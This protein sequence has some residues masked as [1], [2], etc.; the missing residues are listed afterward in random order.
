MIRAKSLKNVLS[1]VLIF[2]FT[3]ISFSDFAFK[4]NVQEEEN[5]KVNLKKISLQS[6]NA[7][8]IKLDSSLSFIKNVANMVSYFDTI[9][10]SEIIPLL[11]SI[12]KESDFQRI[13][14]VSPDGTSHTSDGKIIDVSNYQ[15]FKKAISGE[16]NISEV[17]KSQ[18]DKKDTFAVATPIFNKNNKVIGILYGSY[19]K[20]K[21]AEFI[22]I[23]SFNS[24]GYIDIFESSGK[25]VL[26]SSHTNKLIKSSSNNIYDILKK[27][28]F[29]DGYSYKKIYE[30]IKNNKSGFVSYEYKG[31]NGYATY[32]PID[33]NDWYVLSVI[34]QHTVRKNIDKIN[35]LAFSLIFKVFLLFIIL[36]IYIF[37]KNNKSQRHILKANKEISSITNS[38][39][40]GVQKCT[41]GETC[42]FNFLSDGFIDLFGYTREEIKTLFNNNFYSLIHKDDVKR[43]KREI[44]EQVCKNKTIELEYRVITKSGDTVWVLD[45]GEL[46]TEPDG[47]EYF[48][49]VTVDITRT[50]KLEKEMKQKNLELEMVSENILGGILITEFNEDFTIKYTNSGYLS[51]IGYTR[52]QL[53]DELQSKACNLIFYDDRK[54]ALEN[55]QHQLNTK[56][57]AVYEHRI[58]RRDGN[59][60]WVSIKGR[61][62]IDD[63]GIK[64]GIWII[65]DITD[66]KNAEQKLKINEERF[67]I[68]LKQTSNT[69]FEYDIKTKSLLNTSKEL[70]KYNIYKIVENVPYSLVES[71]VIHK[72]FSD[73]FINMYENVINGAKTASCVVKIKLPDGSYIWN[74][75]TLTT[76]FDEDGNPVRAIGI[77]EDISKQKE[78]EIRYNEEGKYHSAILSEAMITYEINVS[79]DT[80]IKGNESWHKPFGI[81]PD[82][83]YSEM[84][85]TIA[86]S[87]IHKDNKEVFL[88]T[89]LCKNLLAAYKNNVTEIKLEYRRM[90][91]ENKMIWVVCTMHLIKDSITNDIKA[92]AYVKD[93]DNQKK[94]EIRLKLKAERDTLTGLYNKGTTEKLINDFLDSEEA[95]SGIHAFLIVDIDNFKSV[96]DN[97]GHVFGD[98]VLFEVSKHLK[99]I[100]RKDD[101][102]GRIGGDEFIAFLKN[103]QSFENAK[104]KAEKICDIFRN[105]YTENKKT[106]KISGTVGISFVPE[107][108]TIFKELYRKADVALY[109]AKSKGKDKYALYDDYIYQ[110]ELKN[111]ISDN[112]IKELNEYEKSKPILKEVIDS[113]DNYMYIVNPNTYEL[114][115][116]NNK[117]E[118]L[119][120]GIKSGETCYKALLKSNSPCNNCPIKGLKENRHSK[121]KTETNTFG[122]N[123]SIA[124][125]INWMEGEYNC[126][127]E[128]IDISLYKK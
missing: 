28:S 103:I 80:F 77:Q 83:N 118:N 79:K 121:F 94:E 71:G 109:Y 114:I 95:S 37:Y 22:D 23:T 124:S 52:E 17:V 40:G 78:A 70:D 36:I 8:K 127:I 108:G 64:K 10:N 72:D 12:S 58:R 21:L 46:I 41:L 110:N 115:I 85:K 104:K 92:L 90:N 1:I 113:I 117:I 74:K 50:K 87:I 116:V 27:A 68:A 29:D 119:D 62:I 105:S 39:P 20:D 42:E 4:T 47:K 33:I 111:N 51:M 65:T 15:Y 45:K 76:I 59:I 30:D 84:V 19:Y 101:I 3:I 125:W 69:I 55:I 91:Q 53:E 54:K 2:L 88:N 43:I 97:L 16:S 66:L 126:L 57:I 34:P 98:K 107:H 63:D 61:L 128:C 99:P 86:N 35:Q 38:I 11:A 123:I 24:E 93:I 100:F 14:I 44:S 26:K 102:V 75:I 73:D 60:I 82:N 13:S 32:T 106:Y 7:I 96:N 31:E 112:N 6:S 89:F 49:C 67:R 122:T 18:I 25:F 120:L 81:K 48:C 56:G 5:N 9:D